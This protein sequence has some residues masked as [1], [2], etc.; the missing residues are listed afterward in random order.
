VGGVITVGAGTAVA[1]ILMLPGRLTV[2]RVVIACLVP[3]AALVA[4]AG[5]DLATGGNSHFTRTVL[6]AH[7]E[8]ALHDIFVR[9]YELAYNSLKRG[10]MPFATAIA[11]LTLAYGFKYR[12][13]I[14][15]PLGGSDVWSAALAGSVAAGVAGSLSN[16]SGPLLL[17]VSTFAVVATVVYIRGDPRL[18]RV[19]PVN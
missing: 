13:R 2:R 16:D 1:A 10:L 8:N 17:V 9:R 4:L 3:L 7:G 12:E 14:F 11:L 19:E 6:H 15:A 18:A 5:L